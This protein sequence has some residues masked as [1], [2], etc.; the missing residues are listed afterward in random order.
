MWPQAVQDFLSAGGVPNFHTALTVQPVNLTSSLT[1]DIGFW[2]GHEDVNLDIDGTGAR[3][4]LATKGSLM[5]EAP[6]YSEGTDIRRH[7]AK[8]F[9]LSTQSLSLLQAYNTRFKPVQT[10]QLCFSQGAAFIG[11]RKLFDG[12]IDGTPQTIGVKGGRATLALNMFSAMRK[13]TRTLTSKKSH[14]SYLLRGGDTSMEY[15]SLT[16]VESD[17]W[18]ARP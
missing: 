6:T 11:A 12:M 10:W 3:T 15:A 18:G 7:E 17:W 2:T 5:I 13:G 8:L 4:L 16:E 14:A 9:G 1:E